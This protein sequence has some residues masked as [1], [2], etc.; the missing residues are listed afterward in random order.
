MGLR[1]VASTL[2]EIPTLLKVKA[3]MV[4]RELTEQDCLARRVQLNATRFADRTAIVFEGRSVTWR[5]LNEQA[6]R[7][8]AQLQAQGVHRGDTVSV[9]M[10]NRIEFLE[11]LLGINKLGATAALIN[12][13]LTHR[14]LVHCISVTQ[15]R[16]CVFGEEVLPAIADIKAELE[17]A[18]GSD[19]L[20]VP[21]GGTAPAPDWAQDFTAASAARPAQNLD[22]TAEVTLGDNAFYIFT[23][24]TTGLPKAAIMTNRRYLGSAGLSHLAG[25]RVTETDCIYLCLP[26]YHATG[27]LIGIGAALCSGASV[28][29]RRRFSASSFVTDLREQNATAFVYIGELCR[30]LLNTPASADDHVNPLRAMMG[31]GL[32]PDVW[33]EFKQRFGVK[34]I[35]EFYGASEGNVAFANLL[36]KDCTIGLT[37]AKVALV[38]YDV[39]A[40]EIVRDANGRCVEVKSGEP[41]LLL[42]EINATS[43]FEGYTDRDATEK[44]IIRNALTD[45]DAWFNTGDL[46]REIDVGYTLGYPHY[47]F[48]DRVGD[49]YRWK[50]ENVSTNEVGEIING[51]DQ[52]EICNVY[53]VEVPGA[54]GR[55]GMVAVT[56]VEGQQELD[57]AR[58]S[59]YV[60]SELP[61]YARPVFVRVQPAIEVTG[62]FKMVKGDLRKQGWDL[63]QIDD[64]LYVMPPR[65]DAYGVLE[66]AFAKLMAAG[67]AGY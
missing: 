49:T 47:Q 2:L 33:M 58:F 62:T 23:S 3:A 21:D 51:F 19:Y 25:L 65:A 5:Q 9:M 40:D 28:F 44:K 63:E 11:V 32:R 52:V 13:N 39:D 31:N 41:G 17:L 48:V 66:P 24:G 20:L 15:S 26:L 56:L 12:T 64:P 42:G 60:N 38:A 27:L 34:R 14:P 4:P 22:A 16:L 37:P 55:A 59:A 61:A 50:G 53:G 30:Y 35:S 36:N 29:L 57:L 18:E 10:E 54:D 45:G 1:D 6:N 7:Y 8:A 46:I 43:A 67:S